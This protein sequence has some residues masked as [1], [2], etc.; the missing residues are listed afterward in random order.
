MSSATGLEESL[1]SFDPAQRRQAL[2]RLAAEARRA[3]AFAPV[4]SNV[5]MHFHSFF[6]FNAEDYSPSRLAWE[7][8][9]AG[10]YA[11]ALCD[12]D[13]LDGLEE[14]L[15][16]GLAL[17]LRAAVHLETRAFLTAFRDADISSPGEPGVTYVMGAGFAR[18][19]AAD[20][21]E[22]HGLLGYRTRARERNLALM[23]RINGHLRDIAVDYE[24]DVL[25]LTP[26]GAATE[27]HIV[28]AY[29]VKARERFGDA[30]PAASFWAQTLGVKPEEAASLITHP[31]AMEEKV[32]S[33]LVKKGGVGYIQ[34]SPDTFPRAEEFVRWVRSCGAVPMIAWLDGTS[35]G[36]R[37][38][39]ALVE[40]MVALGA[41]AL[42][43]IPDR[44]WNVT[45]PKERAL[46]QEKLREIVAVAQRMD[47]PIN[48]GTEMNKRGLPFVDDLAGAA[49]APY[50]EAFLR[51]AR[52]MTG[53]AVLLR[54][55]GYS[56][57]GAAAAADF[58]NRAAR[59]AFF[60]AVGALPP[61][62]ATT[63]ADLTGRPAGEV[64][65]HF[66]RRVST[67]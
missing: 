27:R 20:S 1:N 31:P 50:R 49:L 16:A 41:A 40:H 38:A 45:D 46:K 24:R 17:G 14:F 42:N 29:L 43:I 63:A 15:G 9:K 34:P 60:E 65:D 33:K 67:R 23:D 56:Y 8:R 6:S 32:R 22:G 57:V 18:M 7:A 30:A 66:R 19:P 28:R 61:L 44:N 11:A 53:H 59:N 25:P 12:F 36:E 47:L 37:D 4:G 64:L 62:D 26:S 58:P 39:V 5:N 55:A 35:G 21:P 48:V 10:L 52:V 2:E 3:G 13:V 51:G 54:F